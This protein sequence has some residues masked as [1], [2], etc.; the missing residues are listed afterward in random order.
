VNYAEVE[1]IIT[2][3]TGAGVTTANA[4]TDGFVVDGTFVPLNQF[5]FHSPSEHTINGVHYPLE[6]HMVHKLFVASAGSSVVVPAS[7]ANAVLSKAAVIGIMFAFECARLHERA[8]RPTHIRAHT[9]AP[10]ACALTD[11]WLLA[12]SLRRA[13]RTARWITT[14]RSSTSC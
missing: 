10:H 8:R 1:A 7:T 11:C 14:G 9:H 3:T 5:H 13:C 2:T 12:C 6:M 4:Q